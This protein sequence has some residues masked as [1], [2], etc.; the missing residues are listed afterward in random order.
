MR[1]VRTSLAVLGTLLVAGCSKSGLSGEPIT[2][3]PTVGMTSVMEC[4]DQEAQK[5]GY[6]IIRIDR[7]DGNMVAER[8]DKS[9]DI[10][11]PR[12]YGGGDMI[13]VSRQPKVNDVHPLAIVPSS[14]IMEWLANGSN[15]RAVKPR[16][17]VLGDARALSERCRL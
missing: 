16:E 9:P 6:R 17:S 13:T 12:E 11:A 10:S 15:Q 8:R 14:Y 3:T 7:Q 1:E 5:L 2:L 4:L